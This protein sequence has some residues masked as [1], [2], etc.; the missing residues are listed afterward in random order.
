[1]V[2]EWQELPD[3]KFLQKMIL[4]V[5]RHRGDPMEQDEVEALVQKLVDWRIELCADAALL[6]LVCTESLT[7]DC[8]GERGEWSFHK[9]PREDDA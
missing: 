5:L 8:S 7:V 3:D 2:S 6:N 9:W 1:M 4:A